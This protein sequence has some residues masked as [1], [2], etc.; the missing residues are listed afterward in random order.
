[1]NC[2][3]RCKTKRGDYEPPFSTVS[4]RSSTLFTIQSIELD[5]ELH[6][7][8]TMP[9]GFP[10]S[11]VPGCSGS[12]GSGSS[13]CG[14]FAVCAGSSGSPDLFGFSEFSGMVGVG[15]SDSDLTGPTCDTD[16]VVCLLDT[17]DDDDDDDDVVAAIGR[18]DI[19]PVAISSLVDAGTG[20]SGCS[21]TVSS[22]WSPTTFSGSRSVPLLGIGSMPIESHKILYTL[23]FSRRS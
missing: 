1:M 20:S 7:E 23:M 19:M 18:I 3:C 4:T 14:G 13:G 16:V 11:G 22:L 9:F 6:K 21:R 2:R 8:P 15:S 5:I 12:S 10:L 17:A